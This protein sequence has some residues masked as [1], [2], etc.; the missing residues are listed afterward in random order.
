MIW[1]ARIVENSWVSLRGSTIFTWKWSSSQLKQVPPFNFHDINDC[2]VH[3]SCECLKFEIYTYSILYLNFLKLI[4]SLRFS[5]FRFSTKIY[6]CNSKIKKPNEKHT[7]LSVQLVNTK[8]F[9]WHIP[10]HQSCQQFSQGEPFYSPSLWCWWQIQPH[11]KREPV[12]KPC[13]LCTTNTGIHYQV[14]TTLWIQ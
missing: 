2:K 8:R 14:Y 12:Y 1:S 5:T 3:Y 9:Y 11:C 10:D 6:K 7:W 13:I 4:S